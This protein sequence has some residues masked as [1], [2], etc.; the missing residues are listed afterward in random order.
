[1]VGG[2]HVILTQGFQ[3]EN[4]KLEMRSVISGSA[5]VITG[6]SYRLKVKKASQSQPKIVSI[7]MG[8][9]MGFRLILP[10]KV[11]AATDTISGGSKI[12]QR[13]ANLRG[14]DA[15]LLFGVFLAKNCM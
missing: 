6:S 7:L 5:I 14:T 8:V 13:V 2:A 1:M 3:V 9:R 12:S 4:A 10:V 15:N 11:T